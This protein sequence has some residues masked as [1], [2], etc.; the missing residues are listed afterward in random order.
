[1]IYLLLAILGSAA[2]TLVMKTFRAQKGNRY[3]L[4]LGNYITCVALG[5]ALLPSKASLLS[6][7]RVTLLCGMAGGL[8]YVA[9]ILS[10]QTSIRV[11]GAILT[12]AFSKL[13]L[14]VSLAL[15]ILCFGERPTL[16]QGAG[17]LLVL[18]AMVLI[19][20]RESGAPGKTGGRQGGRSFL[21]LIVTL[22]ACG[23]NDAMAK[24]FEAVGSPS[25]DKLFFFFL[26]L[27]AALFSAL[28][29]AVEYR[30]TKKRIYW[31]EMAAG[32]AVGVPNYLS[33]LLLLKALQ[34]LPAVLVYPSFSTGAILAVTAASALLFRER[35]ARRQLL[36]LGVILA[37]L[38]LLNL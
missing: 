14:L 23:S 17:I 11:N 34:R 12:A 4:I 20:P 9:G 36:G 32:A 15:S 31:R 18:S 5:L 7:S 16:L 10:M 28:L 13:G 27:T 33:S 37:A 21:L 30:R 22:L 8:L 25:E 19:N 38:I 29:A 35:P 2:M 26:F 3:G 1:M 6:P 24:V